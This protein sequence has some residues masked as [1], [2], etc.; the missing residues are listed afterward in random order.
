MFKCQNQPISHFHPPSNAVS[1]LNVKSCLSRPSRINQA[2]KDK[3]IHL[4]TV[5]LYHDSMSVVDK[6][7][8]FRKI[9]ILILL[10]KKR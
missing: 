10:N 5:F 4:K 1:A 7:K 3:F 9:C 6:G 2:Q 8:I